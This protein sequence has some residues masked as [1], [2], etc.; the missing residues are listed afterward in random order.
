MSLT[1][2]F[3]FFGKKESKL[4]SLQELIKRVIKND[5]NDNSVTYE[6]LS[7]FAITPNSLY[8]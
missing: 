5:Y 4:L 3:Y 8:F 7:F 2:H 1:A 6:G